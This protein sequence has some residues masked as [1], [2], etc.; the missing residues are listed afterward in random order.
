MSTNDELWKR[1]AGIFEDVL[2]E[3]VELNAETTA[4]DVDGWDSVK[5]VEIV[6]AIEVAFGVRFTVGEIAN[7]ATVGD[8][9]DRIAVDSG[10][11]EE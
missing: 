10:E 7:L 5:T 11:G 8:L 1:L 9:V 2:G 3:R 6:V 4:D